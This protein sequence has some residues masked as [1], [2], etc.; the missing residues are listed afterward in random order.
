MRRR[1]EGAASA[2]ARESW[3]RVAW[4]WT[5]RS[6]WLVLDEHTRE[7]FYGLAATVYAIV[8]RSAVTVTSGTT[9]LK[10][11]F[12]RATKVCEP[13][14]HPLIPFFQRV[15]VI[16]TR[17]RTLDLPAQRVT[18]LDG[19]VYEVDANLVYR[20]VDVRKALIEIDDLDKGMLQMLALSV[21]DVLRG[22]DRARLRV[23]EGLDRA[24]AAEMAGR[25]APWGVAVERAGLVTINPLAQTARITMLE[26]LARTRLRAVE[27]FVEH[28]VPRASALALLG[29][30]TRLIRRTRRLRA[31]ELASRRRRRW[32]RFEAGVKQWLAEVEETVPRDVAAL[33]LRNAR[34]RFERAHVR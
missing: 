24:L 8:R 10:F 9:G 13:G 22:L 28:G 17:A 5:K 20:V 6:L 31:L 29:T 2:A 27:R 4:R 7:L 25:L 1:Q 19:L 15:R 23:S 12:G 26:A 16:P 34:E 14:F 3:P 33:A 18:T 32:R 30:P 21:Q 11:S